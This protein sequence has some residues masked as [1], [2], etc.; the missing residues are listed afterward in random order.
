[1]VPL[2]IIKIGTAT[3]RITT[4]ANGHTKA[5]LAST[6]QGQAIIAIIAT[7]IDI[8]IEQDI[9]IDPAITRGTSAATPGRI[10]ARIRLHPE[11][12]RQIASHINGGCWSIKWDL[13]PI[14]IA[15]SIPKETE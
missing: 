10:L 7:A 14:D 13:D 8:A 3:E 15:S 12:D 5:D 4:I 9:A 6:K 2:A 11:L 1:M